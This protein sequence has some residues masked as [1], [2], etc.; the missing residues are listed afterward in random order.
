MHKLLFYQRSTESFTR[1]HPYLQKSYHIRR[2]LSFKLN[3]RCHGHNHGI[4][5]S[6]DP[7]LCKSVRLGMTNNVAE[8]SFQFLCTKKSFFYFLSDANRCFSEGA[9]KIQFEN[10]AKTIS[11]N[12]R[13]PRV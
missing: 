12:I 11:T 2:F 3:D 9:T 5:C 7:I 8:G 13:T 10:W 4:V 6:N 1:F